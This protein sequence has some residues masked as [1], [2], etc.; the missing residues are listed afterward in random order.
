MIMLMVSGCTEYG[1][2][3][4]KK[5]IGAALGAIGGAAAGSQ[6]GKGS[7]RVAMIATGTLIG[8]AF[9][10]SLGAS[11]DK[12]DQQY[13]SKNAQNTLETIP[14]GQSTKWQNPDSGNSG[15]LMP[16]KTYQRPSGEYCREYQQTVTIGNKTQEAFG[17]ACRQPDG[18]WKV[19]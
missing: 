9:G 6:F 15:T 16:T 3:L 13:M 7:G 5:D 12:I 1:G 17:K 18:T 4:A 14:T 19:I 11:L 8:A 10:S 2:P